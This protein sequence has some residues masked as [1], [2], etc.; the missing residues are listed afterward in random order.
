LAML[1]FLVV[2]VSLVQPLATHV[3][4][5]HHSSLSM[6]QCRDAD[7]GG[8]A[9][10]TSPHNS[11]NNSAACSDAALPMTSDRISDTMPV[12]L[13]EGDMGAEVGLG[14]SETAAAAG[15]TTTASRTESSMT[16]SVATT[17]AGAAAPTG[18]PE[19]AAFPDSHAIS[20][21]DESFDS[22]QLSRGSPP[23]SV[24]GAA[25]RLMD[26][27]P[28][29]AAHTIDDSGPAGPP[30]LDRSD[31]ERGAGE[32]NDVLSCAAS[33]VTATDDAHPRT[34][35]DDGAS[36]VAT[37]AVEVDIL[38][39]LEPSDEG[40]TTVPTILAVTDNGGSVA[41]PPLDTTMY[42]SLP[43][44]PSGMTTMYASLPAEPSGHEAHILDDPPLSSTLSAA[45]GSISGWDAFMAAGGAGGAMGAVVSGDSGEDNDVV[46]G[47][48][49][50]DGGR[51]VVA[52]G[53]DAVAAVVAAAAATKPPH[54]LS[55]DG[56]VGDGGGPP[57]FLSSDGVM[58]DGSG[59]AE[60]HDEA[61][62]VPAPPPHTHTHTH[63]RARTHTHAHAHA[64]TLAH[65]LFQH[66]SCQCCARLFSSP[67]TSQL[68]TNQPCV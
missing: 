29:A 36:A 1:A 68:L 30:S 39:K 42:A 18:V 48:G 28:H 40:A 8:P 59:P 10:E 62:E 21:N 37:A 54:H 31:E 44:E 66:A 55:S 20:S 34:R 57:H 32:L 65:T 2:R 56:A 25:A 22:R 58:R 24:K 52:V 15:A 43:A 35:T 17:A 41:D 13:R 64:H 14:P 60:E 12:E 51:A 61:A 67:S 9:I 33:T 7:I 38:G 63:V 23:P 27:M 6:R 53:E 4:L 45:R 3:C 46:A 47:R 49:G 11:A 50:G 16:T 19:P 26:S 5:T